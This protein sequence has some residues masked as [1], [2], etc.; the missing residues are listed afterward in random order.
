MSSTTLPPEFLVKDGVLF[1]KGSINTFDIHKISPLLKKVKSVDLSLVDQ[2]DGNI[3]WFLQ[4]SK[5]Q[6][7]NLSQTAQTAKYL[8]VKDINIP[9][10]KDQSLFKSIFYKL[11]LIQ[12]AC[13]L[14]TKLIFIKNNFNS[15]QKRLLIHNTLSNIN[16]MGIKS[17][18]VFMLTMFFLGVV[19]MFQSTYQM[20]QFAAELYAVDFLS[21]SIFRELG[22][23]L[24]GIVLASRTGSAITAQIGTMKN[25]EE[26]AMLE[27]MGLSPIKLIVLPKLLALLVISPFLTLFNCLI[28]CFGGL[29]IFLFYLKQSTQ[30]FL[31]I[32]SHTLSNASFWM[33]AW[34]G[35]LFAIVIGII[36]CTQ[37]LAVKS[38]AI[39][40]SQKTTS[41]VVASLIAILLL[42]GI[43]SVIMTYM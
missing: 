5:V 33:F 14:L 42:D 43:I 21:I 24:T 38:G 2:V 41:S 20:S 1:I 28:S 40:L 6:L 34:K 11:N 9:T 7:L 29:L 10:D 15:Q 25:N 31:K 22:P 13:S 18:P 32:F 23:I 37:G 17:L 16:Q 30:L 8:E 35:P 39:D 27:I 19:I 26:I 12:Q 3:M 4:K 36:S